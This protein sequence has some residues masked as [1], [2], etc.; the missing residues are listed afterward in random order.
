MLR[1]RN[2]G[3]ACQCPFWDELQ[4]SVT[5]RSPFVARAS[6][7]SMCQVLASSECPHVLKGPGPVTFIRYAGTLRALLEDPNFSGWA[8]RKS[9]SLRKEIAEACAMIYQVDIQIAKLEKSTPGVARQGGSSFLEQSCTN[10]CMQPDPNQL[11]KL[12]VSCTSCHV[13]QHLQER[14]RI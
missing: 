2:T 13:L 10:I 14:Q 3:K 9:K 11:G 7:L 6:K 4:R 12:M 8:R 1:H 5:K